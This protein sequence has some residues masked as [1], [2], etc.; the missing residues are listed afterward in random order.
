MYMKLTNYQQDTGIR[1][2]PDP[3]YPPMW[4]VHWPDGTVSSM[5]NL[6]R[7]RQMARLEAQ[8]HHG[9]RRDGLVWHRVI[10]TKE[11]AQ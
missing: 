8:L 10:E 6:A 9:C 7:A 3:Q 2:R 5:A 4:R 11:D 1:V